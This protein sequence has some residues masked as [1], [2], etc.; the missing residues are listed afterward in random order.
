M[1]NDSLH[2]AAVDALVRAAKD[3]DLPAPIESTRMKNILAKLR[4]GAAAITSRVGVKN[5]FWIVNGFMVL[6]LFTTEGN[7]FSFLFSLIAIPTHDVLQELI[8]FFLARRWG[9]KN[10]RFVLGPIFGGLRPHDIPNISEKQKATLYAARSVT[11]FL[12][13][14][15][16]IL[17]LVLCPSFGRAHAPLF[18]LFLFYLA[19]GAQHILPL[20]LGNCGA[21]IETL[22][23]PR[24][25]QRK[26][27]RALAIGNI[28]AALAV[29]LALHYGWQPAINVYGLDGKLI[30][31]SNLRVMAW[32]TGGACLLVA[33][34]ALIFKDYPPTSYEFDKD[35]EE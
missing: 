2:T 35:E 1:L 26:V 10:V 31:H 22:L 21:V 5:H 33:V 18:D 8:P 16:T 20:I 6:L 27:I 7:L 4:Q 11:H 14:C 34:V 25:G 28:I 13:L 12:S 15:V 19:C 30:V 3:G 24:Y 23:S 17:F 9:A 29:L 32:M